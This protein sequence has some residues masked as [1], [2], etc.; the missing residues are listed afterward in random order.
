L[1]VR[2]TEVQN[3]RRRE[4]KSKKRPTLAGASFVHRRYLRSKHVVRGTLWVVRKFKRNRPLKWLD[5]LRPTDKINKEGKGGKKMKGKTPSRYSSEFKLKLVK[6]YLETD[7][8][9]REMGF[10][11]DIDFSVISD[12]VNKYKV[13]KDKAFRTNQRRRYSFIAD[14]SKIPVFLKEEL[15]LDK[16]DE[17]GDTIK[18]LKEEIE[19][20]KSKLVEKDLKIRM[21]KEVSKKK[22]QE[23]E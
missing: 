12:W 9:Y 18:E 14:E 20:L 3:T 7:M 17:Y 15:G 5:K 21:L 8:S 6:E 19:R 23:K 2:C 10:K 22:N 1:V 13:Y 11:Y 16:K 4:A